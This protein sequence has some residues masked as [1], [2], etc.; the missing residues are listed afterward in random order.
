MTQIFR[1]MKAFAMVAWGHRNQRDKAG[2]AYI[3]HL[4]TVAWIAYGLTREP[5]AVVVG[6]LHDYVEDVYP[7][8]YPRLVKRFGGA[9]ADRVLKLTRL[10]TVP[11][12]DYALAVSQCGDLIV[13]NVKLADLLHNTDG[14]R[15][16]LMNAGDANRHGRTNRYLNT[17]QLM[18]TVRATTGHK[19]PVA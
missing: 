13:I 2:K 18:L 7:D 8:A 9:T 6:L 3:W 5:E 14:T 1:I 12:P 15:R 17:L 10:S 11:Y 4:V 16:Y 19:A